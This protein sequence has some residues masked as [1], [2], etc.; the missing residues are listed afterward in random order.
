MLALNNFKIRKQIP[1]TMTSNRKKKYLG[2][3]LTKQVQDLS[4]EKCKTSLKETGLDLN[5]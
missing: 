4:I 5:T 2:K 3:Q 1:F